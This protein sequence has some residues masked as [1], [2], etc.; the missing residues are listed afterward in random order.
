MFRVQLSH[1]GFE[2]YLRAT[3]WTRDIARADKFATIAHAQAAIEKA[4]QFNKPRVFKLA[5]IVAV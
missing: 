1:E 3:I 5:R 2:N 4:R